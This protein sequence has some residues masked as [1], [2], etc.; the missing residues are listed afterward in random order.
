MNN[1]DIKA[2]LNEI[3]IELKALADVIVESKILEQK[4]IQLE[5]MLI[6]ANE[7]H[8]EGRKVLHKRLDAYAKIFI[9][10]GT[11]LFTGMAGVI[12]TLVDRIYGG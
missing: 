1:E 7:K 3:K 11:T 5:Q 12:W 6:S 10:F 9:W 4:I 2:E 8:N